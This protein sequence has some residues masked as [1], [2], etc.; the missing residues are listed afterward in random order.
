MLKPLGALVNKR[1]NFCV[2]NSSALVSDVLPTARGAPRA[3]FLGHRIF[4]V[5]SPNW[6]TG[7]DACFL[8][9]E[10]SVQPLQNVV[11]IKVHKPDTPAGTGVVQLLCNPNEAQY[12]ALSLAQAN[13]IVI[14]RRAPGDTEMRPMEIASFRS[15]FK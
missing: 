7:L 2:A 12:A 14:A 8:N 5:Q 13:N 11:V 6:L 9:L 1:K 15:L 3:T 4:N 10:T